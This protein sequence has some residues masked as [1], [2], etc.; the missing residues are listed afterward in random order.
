MDYNDIEKYFELKKQFVDLM[1][2]VSVKLCVIYN[3]YPGIKSGYK[4]LGDSIGFYFDGG[5]GFY[6]LKID[7][8]EFS[9]LK[10]LYQR[11]E[12]LAAEGH[13]L[14]WIRSEFI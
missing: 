3:Y 4:L 14:L 2:E 13:T 7:I 5:D 6:F 12:K 8:N 9:D 1:Y 11:H 10:T